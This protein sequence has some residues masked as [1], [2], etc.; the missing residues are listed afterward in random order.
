[1]GLGKPPSQEIFTQRRNPLLNLLNLRARQRKFFNSIAQRFSCKPACGSGAI[2]R[3]FAE[4]L[5]KVARPPFVENE[6]T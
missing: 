3:A 5:H 6:Q 4:A 1:M 2:T